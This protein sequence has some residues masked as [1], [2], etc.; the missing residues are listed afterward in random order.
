[1][2][3]QQ[4]HDLFRLGREAWNTWAQQLLNERDGIRKV[5]GQL[6]TWQ[7]SAHVA[8]KGR[9]F[10]NVA[11]FYELI[12]PGNVD[13]RHAT[14]LKTLGS[15]GRLSMAMPC[16]PMRDLIRAQRSMK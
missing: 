15:S 7:K 8:F 2:N 1:M 6:D 5:G 12:F 10:D 14:F 9:S 16:S 11:D 4:T 13:F 3:P